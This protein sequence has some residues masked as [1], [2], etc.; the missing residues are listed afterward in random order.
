MNV[1]RR[2]VRLGVVAGL[3]AVLAG[4]YVVPIGWGHRHG[5]YHQDGPYRGDR[6]DQRGP[7]DGRY[8]GDD[9]RYRGGDDG[10]WQR[11]DDDGHRRGR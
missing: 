1:W 9:G 7:R 6:Y 5:G 8:R 4:C 10:R 2:W 11:G 3:G